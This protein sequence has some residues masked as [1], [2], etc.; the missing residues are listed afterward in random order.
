MSLEE[1]NKGKYSLWEKWREKRRGIDMTSESWRHHAAGFEDGGRGHEPRDVKNTAA[2]AKKSK[3]E[4][5]LLE[6]PEGPEP[7]WHLT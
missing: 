3:A 7:C 6:P 1:E 5:F 2:E 4:H